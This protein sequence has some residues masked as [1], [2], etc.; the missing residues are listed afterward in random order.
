M[1]NTS[2]LDLAAE[3]VRM[4]GTFQGGTGN[5]SDNKMPGSD[6]YV[7]YQNQDMRT[8]FHGNLRFE[9]IETLKEEF[10]GTQSP[11]HSYELI[12][13]LTIKGDVDGVIDM[14]NVLISGTKNYGGIRI[15]SSFINFE[16]KYVA[17]GEWRIVEQTVD[18][19]E[20]VKLLAREM[21]AQPAL[22]SH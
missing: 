5:G 13:T 11:S 1:N 17:P 21:T 12:R 4:E 8:L 16:T 19:D 15:H 20:I 3:Y 2:V 18:L 10:Y 9:L 7:T 22:P 14:E 6:R